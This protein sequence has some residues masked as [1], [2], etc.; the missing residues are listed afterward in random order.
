MN[1]LFSL[2][3]SMQGG[4]AER[5]LQSYMFELRSDYLEGYRARIEAVTAEQVQQAAR[6]YLQTDRVTIV[7]VGDAAK[8]KRELAS[9]GPLSEVFLY[10][11]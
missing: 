1:G 7:V 4:V 10:L 3:L 8:L 11:D 9:L 6:K 2:S 5:T